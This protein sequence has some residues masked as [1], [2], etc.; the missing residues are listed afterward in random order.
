MTNGQHSLESMA[1]WLPLTY[2]PCHLWGEFQE[3]N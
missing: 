2:F 3:K 1:C